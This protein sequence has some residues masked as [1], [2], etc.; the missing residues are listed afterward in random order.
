MHLGIDKNNL[1]VANPEAL[2]CLCVCVCVFSLNLPYNFANKSFS[3]YCKLSV[4]FFLAGTLADISPKEF[5]FYGH[6]GLRIRG[7]QKIIVERTRE[8]KT[9]CQ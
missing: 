5:K 2:S 6:R 8:K 9:L 3:N 1:N 4:T 7:N